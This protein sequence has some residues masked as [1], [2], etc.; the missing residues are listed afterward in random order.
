ML[1]LVSR[2]QGMQGQ[3]RQA[4]VKLAH[5]TRDRVGKRQGF[6]QQ[7]QGLA[8]VRAAFGREGGVDAIVH[9]R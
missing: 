7:L 3:Q 6:G 8:G 5:L 9:Q 4:T 1:S 2:T